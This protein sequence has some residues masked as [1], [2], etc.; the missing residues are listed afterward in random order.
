[1]KHTLNLV[2]PFFLI[3]V[4]VGFSIWKQTMDENKEGLE[5]MDVDPIDDAVIVRNNHKVK[6]RKKSA[7]VTETMSK[8]YREN[9]DIKGAFKK[10]GKSI[11]DGVEGTVNKVKDGVAKLGNDIKSG[12]NKVGDF[13]KD[14]INKIKN[15][16]SKIKE[17][18]EWLGD[19]VKCGVEKI[20]TLRECMLWYLIEIV[21][22]IFYLPFFLLFLFIRATTQINIEDMLWNIVGIIDTYINSLIGFHV[23]YFPQDIIEKCYVCKIRKFPNFRDM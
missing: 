20:K 6:R 13:F 15:F 3:F 23:I 17:F 2:L 18:F 22:K 8:K 19:S 7:K 1:M 4:I 9:L 21:G 10:A 16:V 12:F 5:N 11:K 14:I